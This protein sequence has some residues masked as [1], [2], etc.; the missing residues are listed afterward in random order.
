MGLKHTNIFNPELKVVSMLIRH[1]GVTA[2]A[3]AIVVL[4]SF[5]LLDL[6]RTLLSPLITLNV[7]EQLT[8]MQSA[9]RCFGG[10][11]VVILRHAGLSALR[12]GRR[13]HMLWC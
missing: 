4:T 11:W 7:S 2:N 9:K 12:E 13:W 5:S 6:T 3:P 1:V 8:A 10:I